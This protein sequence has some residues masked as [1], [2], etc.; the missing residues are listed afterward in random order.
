MNENNAE[1]AATAEPVTTAAAPGAVTTD[2]PTDGVETAATPDAQ[3][4]VVI[5][6]DVPRTAP[7]E[8]M[9]AE[10][11]EQQQRGLKACAAL[12]RLIE[13]IIQHVPGEPS[14]DEG[15]V[16]CVIRLLDSKYPDKQSVLYPVWHI[17]GMEDLARMKEY[18]GY[19]FVMDTTLP[20]GEV[21]L[22]T[23]D[24]PI[25]KIVDLRAPAAEVVATE[26]AAEP[27]VTATVPA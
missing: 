16:D 19:A 22:M 5:P 27:A 4:A 21:V 10:L 3:T 11:T 12:D 18:G 20:P 7:T 15:V 6:D 9:P 25:A 23:G 24:E 17:H 14:R 2:T 8:D 13:H 26:P 1:T